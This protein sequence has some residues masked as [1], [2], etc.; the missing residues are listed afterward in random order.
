MWINVHQ[1]PSVHICLGPFPSICFV[2]FQCDSFYASYY[3]LYYS[4]HVLEAYLFYNE[5]QKGNELDVRRGGKKL[6]WVERE[7]I[8]RMYYVRKHVFSIKAK[9]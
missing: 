5:K 2:Q 4:Y 7:Q 6:Q 8:I 9:T 3:I 1:D